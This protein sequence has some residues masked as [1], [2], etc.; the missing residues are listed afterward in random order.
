MWDARPPVK[1]PTNNE[2]YALPRKLIH[3]ETMGIVFFRFILFI[4]FI[5]F[6]YFGLITKHISIFIGTKQLTD[7]NLN[8]MIFNM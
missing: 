2:V 3:S 1:W 6:I 5:L 8:L 7:P 4:L